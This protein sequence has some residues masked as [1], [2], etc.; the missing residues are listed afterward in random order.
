MSETRA[1][2][3]W[4]FSQISGIDYYTIGYWKTYETRMKNRY[5]WTIEQLNNRSSVGKWV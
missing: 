2:D 3:L 5:D 1:N 4:N